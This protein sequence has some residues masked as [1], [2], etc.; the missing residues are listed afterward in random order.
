LDT[1]YEGEELELDSEKRNA[2]QRPASTRLEI[3]MDFQ[4]LNVL[5]LRAATGKMIGTA[6][7]TEARGG[8]HQS[9]LGLDS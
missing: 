5:L 1:T 3:T 2:R 8:I 9:L 4:R 7:M 6:L